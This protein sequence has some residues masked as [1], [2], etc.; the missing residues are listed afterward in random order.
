MF[1]LHTA[2]EFPAAPSFLRAESKSLLNRTRFLQGRGGRKLFME[3]QIGT[4]WVRHASGTMPVAVLLCIAAMVPVPAG[5]D[6]LLEV[7]KFSAAAPGSE[8][9]DNWRPL[10]FKKIP[11]QTVY[12]LVR[13]GERVVLKATSQAAASGLLREIFI[14]PTQ[15]P[16]VQWTWKIANYIQNSD[17]T[18]KDGDDY[19]ARLYITFQYDAGKVSLFERVQYETMRLL[20]GD[21]PPLAALNYIWANTES[22][23]SIVPNVY[24]QRAKMIVLENRTQPLNSWIVEERNLLDDYRRAFG[25]AAAI[26]MIS[27]VAV[28]CDT[29][30]TGES[31]SAYFGDIVFKQQGH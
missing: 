25:D 22:R 28:M 13:D 6:T 16:V 26:P 21:Y 19:P 31:A 8:F 2:P 27:G 4:R 10:I 30:N 1:S 14:D 9:P 20:Y 3:R 23:G 7:G 18:R 24:T 5:A 15:Y 11:R 17:V 12:A 29:D